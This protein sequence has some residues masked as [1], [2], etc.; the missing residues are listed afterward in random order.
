M[1]SE[2]D[3]FIVYE[4]VQMINQGILFFIPGDGKC[5]VMFTYLN[6]VI[7]ALLT[8]MKSD[9][10]NRTY[11]IAADE[12]PTAEEWFREIALHVHRYPPRL[13]IPIAVCKPI[14]ALIKPIMNLRKKRTFMYQ[15]SSLDRLAEGLL[16]IACL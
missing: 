13:K 14:I 12:A 11:I 7:D 4:L 2:K 5:R 10:I 3:F 16:V 15:E 6:D 9:R 1:F 8:A